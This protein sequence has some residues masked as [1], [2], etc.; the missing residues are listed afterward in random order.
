MQHGNYKW[1]Q[2]MALARCLQPWHVSFILRSIF[3]VYAIVPFYTLFLE[4]GAHS[5]ICF[6]VIR[7]QRYIK[8]VVFTFLFICLLGVSVTL[9]NEI[10]KICFSKRINFICINTED[11]I[12]KWVFVGCGSFIQ[13]FLQTRL[14]IYFFML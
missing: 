4:L 9:R 2:S 12:L 3:F 8:P 5:D 6:Q 11:Q 7:S 10:F 13:F 14:L 1:K